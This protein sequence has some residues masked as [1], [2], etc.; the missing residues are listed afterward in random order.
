MFNQIMQK[1]TTKTPFPFRV[2]HTN[3]VCKAG[4]HL[5]SFSLTRFDRKEAIL[6]S[7]KVSKMQYGK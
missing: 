7:E 1:K 3:L 4:K 6:L 2:Y 5:W